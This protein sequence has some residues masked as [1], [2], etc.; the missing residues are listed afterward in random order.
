MS[1]TDDLKRDFRKIDVDNDGFITA[2]E[3]KMALQDNPKVS[4]ANI[5]AIVEMADENGDR[6]I[7][8]KEYAKFVR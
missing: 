7:D 6:R 1:I 3:L 8:L 5:A 4:D 2:D